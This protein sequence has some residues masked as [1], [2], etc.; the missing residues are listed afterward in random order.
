MEWFSVKI[1][2]AKVRNNLGITINKDNQRFS[3]PLHEEHK[4]SDPPRSGKNPP[5]ADIISPPNLF[6][7]LPNLPSSSTH[8]HWFNSKFA[9][10]HLVPFSSPFSEDSQFDHGYPQKPI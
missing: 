5:T 3:A 7:F 4:M 1:P 2:E 6:E 10:E 8:S 9:W